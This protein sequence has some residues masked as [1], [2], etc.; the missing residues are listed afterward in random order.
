[1]EE[2]VTPTLPALL[3]TNRVVTLGLELR[4][5]PSLAEL[6]LMAMTNGHAPRQDNERAFARTVRLAEVVEVYIFEVVVA[7]AQQRR[8]RAS[9]VLSSEYFAPD[10]HSVRAHPA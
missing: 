6:S 2:A 3:A 4:R 10:C 5:E 7:L 1:M 8:V 9:A